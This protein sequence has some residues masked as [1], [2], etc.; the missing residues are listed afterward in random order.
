ML[1][2]ETIKKLLRVDVSEIP[3][4]HRLGQHVFLSKKAILLLLWCILSNGIVIRNLESFV[5]NG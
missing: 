2:M 4:L 5:Q 3:E 1:K